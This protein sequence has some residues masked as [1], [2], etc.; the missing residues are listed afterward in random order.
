L[1]GLCASVPLAAQT[2]EAEGFARPE[3]HGLRDIV[4]VYAG[5]TLPQAKDLLPLVAHVDRQGRPLAWFFDGAV[6]LPS[7]VFVNA[8]GRQATTRAEWER[9]LGALFDDGGMVDSLEQAVAEAA[10]TLGP[11]GRPLKAI[12]S[13]AHP[14]PLQPADGKPFGDLD[15]DGKA[16]VLRTVEDQVSAVRW[17]VR[18]LLARWRQRQRP[19]LELWGFYWFPESLRRGDDQLVQAVAAQ[20]HQLNY[21]LLWIPW[22]RAPGWQRW[23]QVGFDLAIMQPNYAFMPALAGGHLPDEARRSETA[24]LARSHGLGVEIETRYALDSRPYDRALLRLYLNHALSDGYAQAVRAH[25]HS[26]DQYQ[27]LARAQSLEARQLYDDLFA[28]H[29]GKLRPRPLSL[30]ARAQV[31][32][33]SLSAIEEGKGSGLPGPSSLAKA[34]RRPAQGLVQETPQRPPAG[35]PPQRSPATAPS[36]S[37]GQCLLLQLDRRAALSELRVRLAEGQDLRPPRAIDIYGRPGATQPWMLLASLTGAPARGND[38]LIATWP[39]QETSQLLLVPRLFPGSK[40]RPVKLLSYS[41]L[42]DYA[43][44]AEG[45]AS[46]AGPK[47]ARAGTKLVN[48]ALG[49]PYGVWPRQQ[50]LYDDEGGELTDGKLTQRGFPDGLT[51]GWHRTGR[52]SVEIDLGRSVAVQAVRAHVEGGGLGAV[53]WPWAMWADVSDDGRRWRL[54]NDKP[55]QLTVTRGTAAE[56]EPSLSLGWLTQGAVVSGEQARYVR[57]NLEP[58][59]W[60]MVSEVE[61]LSG[62][63]NVALGRPYRLRPLPSAKVP[64]ADDGL[65]LTDGVAAPAFARCVGW[66]EH[67]A[68]IVLDLGR[69]ADLRRVAAYVLGGGAGAVW[70]PR[71]VEVSVAAMKDLAQG[72]DPETADLAAMAAPDTDLVHWSPPVKAALPALEEGNTTVGLWAE[73]QLPAG[74][75]R[76]VRVAIRG[77]QGWLMVGEVA[78]WARPGRAPE[79]EAA[80][81]APT[82]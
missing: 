34:P 51:V 76:Y 74:K 18:E 31:E 26:F 17:L 41:L 60:L 28:L 46:S 39:E 63:K 21:K 55:A 67:E 56:D 79:K 72:I 27:R 20:V 25:F 69:E 45:A 54:L 36:L 50:C 24:I 61:V 35:L 38:L 81:R 70:L 3:E 37:E 40:W 78:V 5:K 52:V 53:Y 77:S 23:R 73:A 2:G 57:V 10:K 71:S 14:G 4:L 9:W 1:L 59:A 13:L 29:E 8:T 15:G 16:E 32:V 58:H 6:L 47:A 22:F 75:A 44:A 7:K 48:L 80:S 42:A 82:P 43:V 33:L 49:R 19:E 62:G 30:L 68:A 65:T 64:H 12:L 66:T 11:P